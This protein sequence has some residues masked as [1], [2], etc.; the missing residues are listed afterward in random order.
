MK[1][2]T[3]NSRTLNVINFVGRMEIENVTNF[4]GRREKYT[5]TKSVIN[6]HF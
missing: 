3:K 1:S 6:T 5:C 2:I 4:L